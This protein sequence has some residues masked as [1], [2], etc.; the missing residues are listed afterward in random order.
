GGYRP[1]VPERTADFGNVRI[2]YDDDVL[3]PRAW[4]IEQS[5]WAVELA[6]DLSD[7]PVL[8]LC[9]GAG[10]IG[11]LVAVRTGRRLV[12]VDADQR[13]C[14][15]A[16]RNAEAAGVEPDVRCGDL[17]GAVGRA[18]RFPLVLADPPYIRAQEVD[19]LPEDPERAIDGGADGLD[20]ARACLG[21]A[22]RHLAPDGRMLIQLGGPD[23]AATLAAEA[24][25]R[26][27]R[28]LDIR[29]PGPDRALLL[30]AADG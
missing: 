17:E 16:L 24:P 19:D 2:A 3:E 15:Y 25:A 8:E 22:A 1:P 29:T 18:E 14:A 28:V 5:R 20:V 21:V 10:Q 30:L 4:T 7:G 9:A 26:G 27:L 23:Q 12:Q 11:L 13:A 6:A